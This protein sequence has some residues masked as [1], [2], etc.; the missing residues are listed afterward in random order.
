VKAQVGEVYLTES[1]DPFRR[2]LKVTDG[3]AREGVAE[4]RLTPAQAM[5]LAAQLQRWA[6]GFKRTTKRS[7]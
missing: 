6:L 2:W 3:F 5:R 7:K 4:A 1:A